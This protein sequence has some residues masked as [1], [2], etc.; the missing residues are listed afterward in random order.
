[1]AKNKL[2]FVADPT[3]TCT[4]GIPKPGA[5]FNTPVDFTAK[6]RPKDEF[7]E[8]Q[9]GLD[10]PTT[11]VTVEIMLDMFTGWALDVPFDAQH[12]NEMFRIYPGSGTACYLTYCREHWDAKLGASAK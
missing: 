5:A 10:I 12:I 2:S 6:F 1:M 7:D 4:V 9:K 8:W 3:F 11:G